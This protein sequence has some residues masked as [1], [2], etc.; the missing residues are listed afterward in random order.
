MK[1]LFNVSNAYEVEAD[2]AE[3]ATQLINDNLRD[4]Q[5]T[6]QEITLIEEGESK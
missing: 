6:W 3:M 5:P 1:Y 4:Y 2:T